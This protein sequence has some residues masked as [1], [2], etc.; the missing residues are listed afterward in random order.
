MARIETVT[1]EDIAR[2]DESAKNSPYRSILKG[3]ILEIWRSGCWLEEEMKKLGA[4]DQESYDCCFA[5]G[6]RSFGRDPWVMAVNALEKWKAG[7]PDKPGE[8][9]AQSLIKEMVG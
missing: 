8:E 7:N 9:L 4:T 5:H 2:W 3:A 1:E 6:Q